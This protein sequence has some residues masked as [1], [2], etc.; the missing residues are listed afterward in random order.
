M[1][2]DLTAEEERPFAPFALAMAAGVG[3]LIVVP[4][5]S[6]S[7]RAIDARPLRTRQA[8]ACFFC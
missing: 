1:P 2:L 3:G 5:D 4:P 6:G 7:D 8:M